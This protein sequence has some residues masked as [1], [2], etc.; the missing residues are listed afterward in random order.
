MAPATFL[1]SLFFFLLF[2]IHCLRCRPQLGSS[3]VELALKMQ[4]VLF[5]SG[6]CVIVKH[7][8]IRKLINK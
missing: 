8:F 3:L 5:D 1:F 4:N 7:S 6:S 2:L